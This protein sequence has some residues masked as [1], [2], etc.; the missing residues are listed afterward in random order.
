MLVIPLYDRK[1]DPVTHVQT[2]RTW[3]NIVKA[4]ALT[5]C[6]VFALTLFGPTEAWFGRLC[7]GTISSFEQLKEQFIT[8][9]L[10]S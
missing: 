1:M 6:N 5:L 4:D 2:Y 8:Q 10:T 7:S 3:M 9:F